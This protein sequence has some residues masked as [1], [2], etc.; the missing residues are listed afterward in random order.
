MRYRTGYREPNYGLAFLV[1]AALTWLGIMGVEA[2]F[3]G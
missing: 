1:I 2:L 3:G